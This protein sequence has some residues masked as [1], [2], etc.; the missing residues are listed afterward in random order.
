VTKSIG[1]NYKICNLNIIVIVIIL[2]S[3]KLLSKVFLT[4][5]NIIACIHIC[6]TYQ[7]LDP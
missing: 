6:A 5:L 3:V 4:H 7:C 2:A 1:D